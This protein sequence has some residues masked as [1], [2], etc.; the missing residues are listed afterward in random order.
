MKLSVRKKV[1]NGLVLFLVAPQV[2]SKVHEFKD[3][4]EDGLA[5]FSADDNFDLAQDSGTLLA[6]ND[7]YSPEDSHDPSGGDPSGGDP[8]GGD[9]SGGDP[10]GGD[11]SGG[12]PSGGD[13]SGGDPSGGDPSGGDPSGGDPS[14]G[15]PPECTPTIQSPKIEFSTKRRAVT[16]TGGG[17]GPVRVSMSTESVTTHKFHNADSQTEDNTPLRSVVEHDDGSGMAVQLIGPN[18]Q[19]PGDN[20]FYM[21]R[22]INVS[23]KEESRHKLVISPDKSLKVCQF[24]A[25]LLSG[26]KLESKARL[27]S[28]QLQFRNLRIPAND[29]LIVSVEIEH[30]AGTPGAPSF[31]ADVIDRNGPLTDN[32]RNFS[33]T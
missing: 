29:V 19:T 4:V 12:D 18:H 17:S 11:P 30:A 9:P 13:P 7:G 22:V 16:S 3:N 33:T 6:S 20:S 23:A 15:E 8:S 5:A 32:D 31:T 26:N 21:F 14:G 28:G 10:S 2:V 24:A 25:S 1:A 27:H